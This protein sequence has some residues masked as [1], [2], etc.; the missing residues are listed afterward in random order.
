M[1]PTQTFISALTPARFT[2]QE[3]TPEQIMAIADTVDLESLSDRHLGFAFAVWV[4]D[5]ELSTVETHIG[6]GQYM[7]GLHWKCKNGDGVNYLNMSECAWNVDH[8]LYTLKHWGLLFRLEKVG[9]DRYEAALSSKDGTVYTGFGKEPAKALS[10][11][12]IRAKRAN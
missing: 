8:V 6:M 1:E 12:M 9:A 5:R 7:T 4:Y 11:A 2:V 3:E 10:C